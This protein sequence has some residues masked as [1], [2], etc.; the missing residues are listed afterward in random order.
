F[1]G[2]IVAGINEQD[3]KIE[4]PEHSDAAYSF[5]I[6]GAKS[7]SN[8][9]GLVT[10]TGGVGGGSS[11][12]GSVHINAGLGP[13]GIT[14]SGDVVVGASAQ[15]VE[16]SH[17]T[18]HTLIN[19]TLEVLGDLITVGDGTTE[20]VITRPAG[21]GV[22]G[23]NTQIVGQS[24]STVGGGIE[25]TPGCSTDD[26]TSCSHVLAHS[27]IKLDGDLLE[28]GSSADSTYTIS[29]V[30]P[31]ASTLVISGSDEDTAGVGG[32]VLIQ[33]GDSPDSTGSMVTIDGGAAVGGQ[34]AGSVYV[35]GASQAVDISVS[36]KTTTVRGQ[37]EVVETAQFQDDVAI[38]GGLSVGG[39]LQVSSASTASLSSIFLPGYIH[40]TTGYGIGWDTTN[41]YTGVGVDLLAADG[42]SPTAVT[43]S[44]EYTCYASGWRTSDKCSYSVT[45]TSTYWRLS[46]G[47]LTANG[48]YLSNSAMTGFSCSSSYPVIME[49]HI[50][51]VSDP[52]DPA[53]ALTAVRSV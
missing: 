48:S 22:T 24:G 13:N 19:N 21:S 4:R 28:L 27:D 46:G 47:T 7:T 17:S 37:L 50:W 18:G 52:T 11:L 45:T 2:D 43:M 26:P 8:V 16:L 44:V 42:T 34:V 33:G 6:I 29:H 15:N 14:D 35:G 49:L 38:D 41:T 1:K 9:G 53:N 23:S 5:D 20:L 25:L 51:D 39:L 10:V 31:S 40:V 32:H 30:G 12:G 3:F 36:T